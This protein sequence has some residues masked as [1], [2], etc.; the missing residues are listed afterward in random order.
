MKGCFLEDVNF[1][2]ILLELD[3]SNFAAFEFASKIDIQTNRENNILISLENMIIEKISKFI[4]DEDDSFLP[5]TEN[6]FSR[7]EIER[8]ISKL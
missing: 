7:N 4:K 5:E 6:Y 1:E 2:N 8:F 3:K